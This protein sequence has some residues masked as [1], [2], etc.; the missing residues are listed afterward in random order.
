M[1]NPTIK[2]FTTLPSPNMFPFDMSLAFDHSISP[3]YKVI[4]VGI[5]L[6]IEIYSSETNSWKQ[7]GVVFP[8]PFEKC[9][10]YADGVFFN[11]AIFWTFCQLDSFCYFDIDRE[12][13]HTYPMPKMKREY[14]CGCMHDHLYLLGTSL[15]E[16]HQLDIFQLEKDYSSWSLNYCIDLREQMTIPRKFSVVDITMLFVMAREEKQEPYL[17]I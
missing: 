17:G 15:G 7:S 13:I 16:W 5:Y 4:S 2:Q 14:Y 8:K 6:H 3:H 12:I 9:I 10:D 11:G 1:C